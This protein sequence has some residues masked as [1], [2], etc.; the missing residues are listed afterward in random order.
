MTLIEIMIV[1]AIVGVLAALAVFGVRRWINSSHIAEATEMVQAIGGAQE[2][3]RAEVGAYADVSSG[4]ADN[5]LC[6]SYTPGAQ[7][8]WDAAACPHG[9][10]P[11]T[12]LN[13]VASKQLWYGYATRAGAQG[14]DPGALPAVTIKGKQYDYASMMGTNAAPAPYYIV[15]AR[16]DINKN[17]VYATVFYASFAPTV[18]VDNDAE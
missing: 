11:W 8:N 6:P 7:G 12:A 2:Q 15:V 18:T 9:T 3:Y 13:V 1:V 5:Q 16:G 4:L 17:G 10:K 14:T